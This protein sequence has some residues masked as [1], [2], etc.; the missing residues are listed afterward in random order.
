MVKMFNTFVR[1]KLEYASS[2][3]N[4]HSKMLINQIENIQRKFT[5]RLPG[6]S[7]KSYFERLKTLKLCTL[8]ERRLRLDLIFLYKILKGEILVTKEKY[9]EFKTTNTRG[10]SM[11]LREQKSK[12]DIKKYSFA[13]RIVKVW[14]YLPEDIVSARTANSFKTK[15]GNIDLT[16]FL[17]GGEP[18]GQN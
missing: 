9:F 16:K 4:P 10:H 2:I 12:K 8:E 6:L 7:N 5:K 3:W 11:A 1:S 18:R 13:Q 17:R 14:N 15:L